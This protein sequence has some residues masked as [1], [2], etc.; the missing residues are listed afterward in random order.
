MAFGATWAP[1][2]VFLVLHVIVS[3]ALAL[4]FTP[5]FTA[6]LGV[7][8]SNLYGHGSALLSTMQQVAAAAGTALVI[9]VMSARQAAVAA[10]GVPASTA[11]AQGVGAGLAVAAVLGSG[12]TLVFGLIVAARVTDLTLSDGTSRTSMTNRSASS[13]VRPGGSEAWLYIWWAGTPTRT[14]TPVF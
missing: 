9:T 1:W 6:G 13:M 2:P 5:T 7:L 8:P 10:S 14:R 4:V 12:A 11:L 3:L